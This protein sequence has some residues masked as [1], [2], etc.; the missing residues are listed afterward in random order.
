MKDA[1]WDEISESHVNYCLTYSNARP[2][3]C[4]PEEAQGPVDLADAELP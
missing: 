1:N 3:F 4:A 2:V